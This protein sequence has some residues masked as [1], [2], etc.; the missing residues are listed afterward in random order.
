TR[1]DLP[2]GPS[3][4]N[5]LPAQPFPPARPNGDLERL[6]A[7]GWHRIIRCERPGRG[8][9]FDFLWGWRE[10]FARVVR[11]V[12]GS[13]EAPRRLSRRTNRMNGLRIKTAVLGSLLVTSMAGLALAGE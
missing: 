8:R 6:A 7:A 13:T 3:K 2:Y 12:R 11:K 10:A 1:R 9:Y 4:A 5:R